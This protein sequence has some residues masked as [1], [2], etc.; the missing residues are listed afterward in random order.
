MKLHI[1][2]IAKTVTEPELKALVV[3]IAEPSSFELIKDQSGVSKGYGFADFTD[4][5][6]AN[7]VLKGLDGK[8]VAGQILKLG[9]AR[10][11]KTGS[12]VVHA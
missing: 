11:R 12:K 10:P 5:A 8:E 4:D 1:G 3:A 2:N 6:A 9:E 7:A